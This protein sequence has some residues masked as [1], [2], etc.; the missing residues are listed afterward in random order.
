MPSNKA[1]CLQITITSNFLKKHFFVA[2]DYGIIIA[3]R[4]DYIQ[5]R[6]NTLQ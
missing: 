2:I 1:D 3:Y 4:I 5:L 6:Y